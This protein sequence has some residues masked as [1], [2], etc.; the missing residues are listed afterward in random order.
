V[1]TF[2][3]IEPEGEAALACRLPAAPMSVA[4]QSCGDGSKLA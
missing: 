3:H 4:L 1:F 2:A